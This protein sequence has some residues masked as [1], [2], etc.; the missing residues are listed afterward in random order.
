[1]RTV[2]VHWLLI[3]V[4][5][6]AP[7]LWYWQSPDLASQQ[8]PGP[9]QVRIVPGQDS[10][11]TAQQPTNTA[12]APQV[13]PAPDATGPVRHTAP[14][15]TGKTRATRREST[16]TAPAPRTATT[17]VE[18]SAVTPTPV[19]AATPAAAGNAARA[20]VR[21]RIRDDLNRHFVYPM[22][23]RRHGWEGEVLVQFTVSPGG[24]IG[25]VQVTRSSGHRILDRS[26]VRALA[27]LK[28][29]ELESTWWG[30][31]LLDIRIPVIY[32]LHE[33]QLHGG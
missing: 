20:W 9:L 22:L 31:Q 15:H 12:R 8:V 18:R 32:Q 29:I 24:H 16:R 33:G 3:S 30:E 1:M 2:P 5:L 19:A 10:A 4:A 13:P 27:R 7:L 28:R 26:A 6:H 21:S 11:Q 23:A 14:Q 17:H 25:N